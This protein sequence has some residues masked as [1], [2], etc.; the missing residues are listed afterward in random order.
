MLGREGNS[1]ALADPPRWNGPSPR[2]LTGPFPLLPCPNFLALRSQAV[3]HFQEETGVKSV[4]LRCHSQ[5]HGATLCPCSSDPTAGTG[6]GG[7]LQNAS[8]IKLFSLA[9]FN[10]PRQIFLA[11]AWEGWE[12]E[13]RDEGK[14]LA[15]PAAS[16]CTVGAPT[17]TGAR[18]AAALAPRPRKPPLLSCPDSGRKGLASRA[19][20][21]PGRRA[22]PP[23]TR[24]LRPV[25]P[26]L[27]VP[28]VPV[29]SVDLAA[30]PPAGGATGAELVSQPWSGSAP[31]T[32]T[33]SE[34]RR[35]GDY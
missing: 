31:L 6:K 26:S 3:L 23:L 12:G 5:G 35:G 24:P 28:E 19:A 30:G 34:E 20:R 18:R 15:T 2:T 9:I 13:K 7:I 10:P 22:P 27:G 21:A 33:G 14:W 16:K 4:K 1:G 11:A 17:A 8:E 29:P 32:K 25:R